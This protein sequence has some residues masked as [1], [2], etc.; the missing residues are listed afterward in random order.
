MTS[1]FDRPFTFG[2]NQHHGTGDLTES[3]RD[4]EPRSRE[5]LVREVGLRDRSGRFDEELEPRS[6]ERREPAAVVQLLNAAAARKR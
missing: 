5:G 4:V 6:I 1:C 2:T 3:A